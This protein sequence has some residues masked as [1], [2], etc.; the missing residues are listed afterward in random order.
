MHNFKDQKVQTAAANV[1]VPGTAAQSDGA[2]S[3]IGCVSGP[4][5]FAPQKPQH[6]AAPSCSLAESLVL[7][8]SVK[9]F[10]FWA[11]NPRLLLCCCCCS[12]QHVVA[13]VEACRRQQASASGTH[14]VPRARARA[15]ARASCRYVRLR[16]WLR[17]CVTSQLASVGCCD[18]TAANAL[19][20]C[21]NMDW[22]LD[23]LL[24]HSWDCTIAQL[25]GH[26]SEN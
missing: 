5:D 21:S 20:R 22:R 1:S 11:S 10:Y 23:S 3:G 2:Q 6:A 15:C 17:V 26:W 4:K 7:S 9:T 14:Y 8:L 24:D 19:S 18:V 12:W 16:V 25:L 13:I